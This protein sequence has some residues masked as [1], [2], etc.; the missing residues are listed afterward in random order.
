MVKIGAPTSEPWLTLK[1]DE[2]I[3]VTKGRAVFALDGGGEVEAKAGETVKIEAGT[4]FQPRF[5]FEWH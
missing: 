2:W 3:H 5:P 1:Y 4:R